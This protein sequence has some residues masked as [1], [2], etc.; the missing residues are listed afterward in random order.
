MC[1]GRPI[2]GLSGTFSSVTRTTDL[3]AGLTTPTR[4]APAFT[5]EKATII[6]PGLVSSTTGEAT[7]VHPVDDTVACTSA[8]QNIAKLSAL[9]KNLPGWSPKILTT[10]IAATERNWNAAE[11]V[12]PAGDSHPFVPVPRYRCSSCAD[13]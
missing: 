7:A 3:S 11:A 5:V 9:P 2:Q 13:A 6:L 12:L 4:T 10:L 8:F 1:Q